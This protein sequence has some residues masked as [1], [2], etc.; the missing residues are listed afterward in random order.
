M[1]MSINTSTVPSIWKTAKVTPI[2]KSG[3]HKLP[4]NYR[5]ISVLPVISKIIE[6]AVHHQFLKFLEDNKLLT[7]SQFGFCKYRSTKLAA[8]LLCDDIRREMNNGN[9]VGAVY[10]DLSK[11][12]DTIGHT[13][14][15]NK[16]SAYGV[17]GKEL[18]WFTDYLFN[19]TQLVEIENSRS[20]L[21]LI[22]C[23]VL[24]GS[25][26]GPLL[27]IV[28][29]NDPI[30]N[31]N[32]HVIKYADDTV[33]YFAENN[34]DVI[35]RVLNME[36]EVIGKY[37]SKNEL[38]LNLKKGKT[39]AMLF[40]TAKRLKQHDRDLNISYN[41]TSISFVKEYVYL[42]NIIDNTLTL[43]TNFNRAYKRASN[44]LRLLKS[45]LKPEQIKI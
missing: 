10:L 3:N 7:E 29:F 8:A 15:L 32:C 28:F 11:A 1:N 6:K 18:E 14:L 12:F 42:G 31:I 2:F 16:L 9:M 35:E 44:R 30:E 39:E 38:L 19:M 23:G 5:P 41:G 4:A 17:G 21:E 25:I 27:L 13:I 20:T 34:A 37:C 33:L 43:N 36:M 26:L 40:G 22:Y 24:Q 45:V